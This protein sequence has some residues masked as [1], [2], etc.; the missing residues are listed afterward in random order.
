MSASKPAFKPNKRQNDAISHP[1][2][3][4]MILAG[5]GTGKTDLYVANRSRF[6]GTADFTY[7]VVVGGSI[8]AT[9][10]NLIGPDNGYIQAGVT[11]SAII[12]VGTGG[13]V[14]TVSSS[15]ANPK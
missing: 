10:Y 13:T 9:S 15:T 7:D 2:S 6:I 3:P 4:L 5:A 14:L 8:T 12:N 1:P 11:T